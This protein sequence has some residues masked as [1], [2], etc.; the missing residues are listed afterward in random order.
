MT[1]Q[2]PF[3]PVPSPLPSSGSL[4]LGPFAGSSLMTA[5]YRLTATNG[6]GVETRTVTVR[7]IRIPKLT[8]DTIE[9][10][11]VIQRPDNS[12]RLAAQ[13]RTVARVFVDS[14]ITDGFRSFSRAE[15]NAEPSWH[16]GRLSSRTWFR[17]YRD[18]PERRQRD[19]GS[20]SGSEPSDGG[21][22]TQFRASNC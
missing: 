21:G 2:G 11:Q 17:Q 8:I 7:L 13:K 1:S 16:S 18:A 22:I 9:V 19:G 6:C 12:V 4:D 15:R 14:G 10:V 3:A 5:S 20:C